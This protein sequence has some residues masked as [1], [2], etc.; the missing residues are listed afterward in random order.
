MKFRC[1]LTKSAWKSVFNQNV[2]SLQT[3][4]TVHMFGLKFEYANTYP[5]IFLKV[6]G[7]INLTINVYHAIFKSGFLHRSNYTWW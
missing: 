4:K 6:N 1:G 3:N 5:F 2:K 7:E